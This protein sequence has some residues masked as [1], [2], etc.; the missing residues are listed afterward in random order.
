MP[1]WNASV[2][3]PPPH[4]KRPSCT[5][6]P[7]PC[8][9]PQPIG[10]EH[11]LHIEVDILQVTSLV[12]EIANIWPRLTRCY[13]KTE[14][15]FYEVGPPMYR[16]ESL[17]NLFSLRDADRHATLKRAIG[18]LYKKSVAVESDVHQHI[19]Q[20]SALRQLGK[21]TE[22]GHANL[23]MSFWLY[24]FAF[25]C[26]S[27]VNISKQLGFLQ[28]GQDVEDMIWSVDK[29]FVMVGLVW[30]LMVASI[31]ITD[32][33]DP[34]TQA[35]IPNRCLKWLRSLS[36]ADKSEH[37]LMVWQKCW[38]HVA[39]ALSTPKSFTLREVHDIRT[40]S[41]HIRTCRGPRAC[42][43]RRGVS[44]RGR[45]QMCARSSSVKKTF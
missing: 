8:I 6:R 35:P 28:R 41:R 23:D 26:L 27:E 1:G 2:Y 3:P 5:S 36:P 13:F 18:G 37:A 7:N 17:E 4:K 30:T 29:I 34:S 16:D 24:L 43:L 14:S 21:R 40:S 22:H 45:V 33:C 25:D 9:F 44:L 12:F 31:V 39:D 15:D 11:Y 10:L 19:C 32:G 20:Y 42:R 38:S